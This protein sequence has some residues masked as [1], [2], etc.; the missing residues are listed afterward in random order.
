MDVI[1]TITLKSHLVIITFSQVIV[2]SLAAAS[3]RVATKT[4]ALK[5]CLFVLLPL[6]S[7]LCCHCDLSGAEAQ[8]RPGNLSQVWQCQAAPTVKHLWL[9]NLKAA[10]P[11]FTNV[12]F[13]CVMSSKSHQYWWN[14]Y[15]H[16]S[17]FSHLH[18]GHFVFHHILSLVLRLYVIIFALLSLILLHEELI[19]KQL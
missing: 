14:H 9:K 4:V 16:F 2:H 18:R 15:R 6:E 5:T 8:L 7:F 3:V 10:A 11:L 17:I 1:F 12:A 19:E 13:W